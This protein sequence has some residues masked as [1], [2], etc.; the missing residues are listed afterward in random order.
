M[1]RR[2]LN[3]PR[4]FIRKYQKGSGLISSYEKIETENG[5]FLCYHTMEK[6]MCR[7]SGRSVCGKI[8]E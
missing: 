7:N 5:D 3:Y 6:E 4:F 8:S 2:G 1:K